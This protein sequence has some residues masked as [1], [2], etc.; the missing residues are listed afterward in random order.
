[1]DVGGLMCLFVADSVAVV[2]AWMRRVAHT[3]PLLKQSWK[4]IKFDLSLAL[5]HSATDL[6]SVEL[7]F[8]ASAVSFYS[9]SFW[10]PT[11]RLPQKWARRNVREEVTKCDLATLGLISDKTTLTVL[12]LLKSPR[13]RCAIWIRWIS[14]QVHSCC[15]SDLTFQCCLHNVQPEE[16]WRWFS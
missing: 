3:E 11:I 13:S 8:H 10:I 16:S 1:M 6:F 12:W 14:S 5:A 15:F 2:S 9:L 4:M 7:D